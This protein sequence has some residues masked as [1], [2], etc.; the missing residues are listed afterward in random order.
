M[1]MKI[2]DNEGFIKYTDLIDNTENKIKELELE[3]RNLHEYRKDWI[4]KREECVIYYLDVPT[5]SHSIE[6][7]D[8]FIEDNNF[9]GVWRDNWYCYRYFYFDNKRGW[10]VSGC[11][12]DD[13][14]VYYRE[15]EMRYQDLKRE[16]K[17]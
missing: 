10:N 2:I 9:N 1:A 3:I 7:I 11:S 6:L 17:L 5:Y 13:K 12:D 4:N 14:V 8:R 15:V 16:G